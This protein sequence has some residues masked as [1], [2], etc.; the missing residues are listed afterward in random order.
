MQSPDPQMLA[1]SALLSLFSDEKTEAP[2]SSILCTFVKAAQQQNRDP[3]ATSQGS[4]SLS[5]PFYRS[6]T[7]WCFLLAMVESTVYYYY[8]FGFWGHAYWSVL[9]MNQG[10]SYECA[11]RLGG[12]NALVVSHAASTGVQSR[13]ERED[14]VYGSSSCLSSPY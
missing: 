12:Q 9:Y 8:Y 7:S 10:L 1:I 6:F 2:R 14:I 3:Q 11:M 5:T 4:C 13:R